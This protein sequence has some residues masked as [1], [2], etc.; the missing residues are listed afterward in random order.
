MTP[1]AESGHSVNIASKTSM[2]ISRNKY[3]QT[4]FKIK[5]Y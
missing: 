2:P 5:A 3:S 4:C 1:L